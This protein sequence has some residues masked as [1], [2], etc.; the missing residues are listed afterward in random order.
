MQNKPYTNQFIDLFCLLSTPGIDTKGGHIGFVCFGSKRKNFYLIRRE[1]TISKIYSLLVIRVIL[2]LLFT[3]DYKNL[4][5]ARKMG[6][7]VLCKK[8]PK[9]SSKGGSKWASKFWITF[10]PLVRFQNFFFFCNLLTELYKAS[11]FKMI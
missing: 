3:K 10:E 4:W 5:F 9:V 6:A 8:L 11:C 1:L 2:M 7:W